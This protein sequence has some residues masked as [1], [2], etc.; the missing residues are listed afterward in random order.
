[1]HLFVVTTDACRICR[2][3][4]G[5]YGWKMLFFDLHRVKVYINFCWNPLSTHKTTHVKMFYGRRPLFS[6]HCQ[7]V[8]REYGFITTSSNGHIWPF[9]MGIQRFPHNTFPHK[10]Q[11]RGALMFSLR[12]RNKW[13]NKQ[14]RWLWFETQL[15]SLKYHCNVLQVHQKPVITFVPITFSSHCCM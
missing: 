3:N 14:S 11:W 12:R 2:R 7:T 6:S 1:M 5:R 13:F 8:F 15:C 10:G 4:T 9:V